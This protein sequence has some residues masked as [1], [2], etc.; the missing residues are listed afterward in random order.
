MKT[1]KTV[2][3]ARY[4]NRSL[5]FLSKAEEKAANKMVAG[6]ITKTST[7]IDISLPIDFKKFVDCQ[8][9][10]WLLNIEYLSITDIIMFI[11]VTMN[12]RAGARR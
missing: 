10:L 9:L 7:E 2:K 11:N 8:L 12:A 5:C 4:T 3:V 1:Q 6:T